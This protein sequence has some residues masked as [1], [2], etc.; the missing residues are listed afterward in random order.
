LLTERTKRCIIFL[1]ARREEE[2]EVISPFRRKKNS[3]KKWR[4][5][6]N[7]PGSKRKRAIS[8][9]CMPV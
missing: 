5:K 9:A 2:K 8:L 7:V 1:L 6:G 3:L 4:E